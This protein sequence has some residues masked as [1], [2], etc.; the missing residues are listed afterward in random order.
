MKRFLFT[1]ILIMLVL[2]GMKMLPSV[3]QAVVEPWTTLIARASIAI[4]RW[5]EPNVITFGRVMRSPSANFGVSVDPLCSGLEACIVLTAGILAFPATW[6]ERLGG[7]LLGFIAVQTVNL[8]RIVSLFFIGKTWGQHAFDIAHTYVWQALIVLSVI[9]FWLLWVR[10]VSRNQQRRD[11]ER[12][13]ARTFH[14][15][16][17]DVK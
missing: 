16:M 1:F 9:I 17:E 6:R 8:V 10:Y 12:D 3:Q 5:L 11:A 15:P 13:A 2:F 4:V 14:W 7:L